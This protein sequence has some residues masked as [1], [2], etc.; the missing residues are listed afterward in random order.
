MT[1]QEGERKDKI[2]TTSIFFYEQGGTIRKDI[3]PIR[4][5]SIHFVFANPVNQIW[6]SN[7][8]P[9]PSHPTLAGL[10]IEYRSDT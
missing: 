6:E 4:G 9:Q 8:A 2:I 7:S 10:D 1:G 5:F 3:Y